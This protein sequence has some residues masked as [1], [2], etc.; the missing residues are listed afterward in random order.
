VRTAGGELWYSPG[1]IHYTREQCAFIIRDAFEGWPDGDT[2]QKYATLSGKRVNKQ[3]D[4]TLSLAQGAPR[5]PG[6]AGRDNISEV[7]ARLAR[8][9]PWADV[10]TGELR[11]KLF[12]EVDLSEYWNPETETGFSEYLSQPARD[13]LNYI[14]GWNRRKMNFVQWRADRDYRRK[15]DKSIAVK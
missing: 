15:N 14:S 13:V 10:L 6:T 2:G 8:C 12:K 5:L 9:G 4:S 1:E 7:E 11:G 3:V